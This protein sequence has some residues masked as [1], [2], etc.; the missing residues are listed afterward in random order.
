MCIY[1]TLWIISQSPTPFQHDVSD[2]QPRLCKLTTQHAF[3]VF[4]PSPLQKAPVNWERWLCYWDLETSNP[5]ALA[6]VSMSGGVMVRLDLTGWWNL[7]LLGWHRVIGPVG[8]TNRHP[9]QQLL[10]GVQTSTRG[11]Q[12]KCTHWV[13]ELCHF[14]LLFFCQTET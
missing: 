1:I 9:T 5:I 8:P 6:H 3:L 4:I 14:A 10:W 12:T 11:T 2:I 7:W 13:R